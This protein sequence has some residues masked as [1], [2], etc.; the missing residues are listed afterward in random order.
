ML[1]R[2]EKCS[3]FVDSED[4]AFGSQVACGHCDAPCNVPNSLFEKN[5]IIEDFIIEDFLGKG[6]MGM[7]YKAHQISLDRTV[8]LKILMDEINSNPEVVEGF[9]R[10]ARSAAALNHPN[11]VQAY[12]VGMYE[13]VYYFAMEMVEGE[14]VKEL[15]DREPVLDEEN[16]LA[17]AL[18]VGE[19]LREAWDR[20]K[21]IHRDI[22]PDNIMITKE[23][24]VKLMDLGLSCTHTESVSDSDEITGTP[25]YICPEQI[26]GQLM[27]VRGDLYSLG[28]SMYHMLTGAFPYPASN[29]GEML[30]GHLEGEL[31]PIQEYKED[32]SE[33]TWLIIKKLMEKMPDDRYQ[34]AGEL[35]DAIQ[36]VRAVDAIVPFS[37][38][39]EMI[40]GQIPSPIHGDK[41]I[42]VKVAAIAGGALVFLLI[43]VMVFSGGDKEPVIVVQKSAPTVAKKK[44][45][46]VKKV[47]AAPKI[48]NPIVIDF[49]STWSYYFAS[50]KPVGFWKNLNY[51]DTAWKSGKAM[52]GF[53][54]KRLK[55]KVKV[56]KKP[57]M[58]MY[59][60]HRFTFD[61]KAP[62]TLKLA[63]R[64]DDGAVVYLNGEVIQMFNMREDNIKHGGKATKEIEGKAEEKTQYR[65]V[66][67]SLLKKG[68]NII[69]VE[70]HQFNR[71]SDDQ[72]FDLKLFFKK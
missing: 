68:A 72:Y 27:D 55:T 22:K 65:E 30:R 29:F 50:K 16:V 10:E 39:Q 71:K 59:F 19:A 38:D 69:A 8:A 11:I 63:T 21:L 3:G 12:A 49:G 45:I 2:C 47:K 64:V 61:N 37:Y 18:N 42:P 46:T 7:V 34:T 33:D 51:D 43:I 17:L 25:Q 52:I 26:T 14:T 62:G 57:A 20:K 35:V 31:T 9:V 1:F 53:G 15:M 48:V 44:I 67:A 24:V 5:A 58:T 70:V 32:L 41:K 6:G 36:T 54:D 23:G 56:P 13:G 4:N 66:N 60:R 40:D 28:A